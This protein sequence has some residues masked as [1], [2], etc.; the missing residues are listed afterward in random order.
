[1]VKVHTEHLDDHTA[2]LTVE[3]EPEQVE[4]AMRQVARKLSKKTRIPGFRPGKAPFNVVVRM[5]GHEYVLS[6]ALD[7][8]LDEVYK[9]A[10]K[11]SGITP[12]MPG[13]LEEVEE[14][15]TRLVFR[16]AKEPETELGDYRSIRVLYEPEEVTD[17]QIAE[18]LEGLQE[19][20]AEREE[21][22]RPAEYGDQLQLKLLEVVT[23]PDAE[24][25][26]P[27][28]DGPTEDNTEADDND[29][30]EVPTPRVLLHE[31]NVAYMV[32]DDP[33]EDIVPGMSEHFVGAQAGDAL[34]FELTW[35]DDDP[36]SD[37]AGKRV[38]VTARVEKV[39]TRK[40]PE[41]NDEFAKLASQG[42]FETLEELRED[43]RRILENSAQKEAEEKTFSEFV[44]QLVEQATLRYPP[45][46]VEEVIDDYLKA[47]EE[48]LQQQY[49]LD[50]EHY[51]A[52][53]KIDK[54]ELRDQYR[55]AA[56]RR[57]EQS[58]ALGAFA[59][60]EQLLVSEDEI[61]KR[62]D[63]LAAQLVTDT[64]N[65]MMISAAKSVVNTPESRN[66]I[67]ALMLQERIGN[68]LLAIARGEDPPVGGVKP[69]GDVD[70]ET[71]EE[72]AEAE[73]E[74][75]DAIA[76]ATKTAEAAAEVTEQEAPSDQADADPQET[77]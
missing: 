67:N 45:Q 76:E 17:E 75:P 7:S 46:A 72:T 15:G 66:H 58:L 6:E 51:L 39:Y 77:E 38:R 26:A 60:A 23:V 61:S 43:I 29:K 48:D 8:M 57:L 36:E 71:D 35:P 31:H 9:E 44:E 41:I 55:E 52:L 65:E 1:M 63:E 62:A 30:A 54:E 74:Q 47:F 27:T 69:E 19:H 10:L 37:L 5:L 18:V 34:E 70:S 68:Q 22:Q 64:E 3:L 13:E 16:V 11:N 21:V 33:E 59:R 25:Q 28:A 24:D 2:R 14:D 42:K 4:K 32:S 12:Y 56:T 73:N 40:L 20:H 50:L 49:G 53:T